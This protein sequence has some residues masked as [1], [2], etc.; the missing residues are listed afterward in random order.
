ME[1]KE[2]RKYTFTVE[3]E[4]EK[5]YLDWLKKEINSDAD[6]KYTVIINATVQKHPLTFVKRQNAKSTPQIT[7]LCD[8]ESAGTEDIRSF[9]NVL[10]EMKKAKE[11]KK[12]KYLLGYSNL[13]FELWMILH[14]MDCSGMLDSKSQYLPLINQAF[15]ERF[16][17]LSKYKERDNFHRCLSKLSIEDVCKAVCRA[18]TI[19]NSHK[20]IHREVNYAS[21]KYYKENPSLSIWVSIKQILVDCGYIKK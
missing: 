10:K 1:I 16:E 3:G 5:W 12:L 4:T 15:G 17:T 11:E 9:E 18:E 7:H 13:T 19:M 14:K 20:K 6:S 2:K 8:V 21:Y